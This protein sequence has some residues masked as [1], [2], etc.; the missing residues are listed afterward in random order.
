[1]TARRISG[2]EVASRLEGVRSR[3]L[4]ALA[5]EQVGLARRCLEM[6][7]EYAGTRQQ[8]GRTIGSFQGVKHTLVDLLV[9]IELAEA[10]VLDAS[11]GA[12]RGAAEVAD[13]AAASR[14]LASRAA[15]TAAEE[16]IQVHGEHPLHHYFRRAKADQL[17]FGDEY[18][19][20]QAIGES[21][22][23]R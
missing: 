3:V 22:T 18:P 6:A 16:A 9:A 13:L 23:A 5:A 1:M 2:P 21:L 20:V 12:E 7:V 10:T 14:V 4:I 11:G 19:Y 8:F 17:L 15:M